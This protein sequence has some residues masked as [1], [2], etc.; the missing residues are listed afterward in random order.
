MLDPTVITV[1]EG[2]DE[3]PRNS[4]ASVVELNDG[5]LLLAWQQYLPSDM[6]CGDEAPNRI[7]A[8]TSRD[9]GLTWGEPGVLIEPDAG[10]TNVYSPSFVRLPDGELL[11]GYFHY[12]LLAGGEAPITSGFLRRSRDDGATW[13]D[14]QP[15]W[16]RQPL[17]CASHV[18]KRLPGGRLIWPIGK[19]IGKVWTPTDHEVHG[20]QYS[21]D[22]GRTWKLCDTWI[23]LPMRGAMEG[24]VEPLGDGRVM[25]VMR[26]QLGSVFQSFSEDG[27]ATWS[28]AQTTGLKSPESCP[29]LM[30]IPKTGDLLIV[31]NNSM[32]DPTWDGRNIASHFGK[33]SPLTVAVS[34]DDGQTWSH[35]RN[36]EDDPGWGYTNPAV[37]F[38]S[39][40]KGIL[41][42]FCIPYTDQWSMDVRYMHLRAAVFDVD[43][44]Y[45]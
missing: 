7:A 36:I 11:L 14:R 33:R 40:G 32:Y 12:N 28:K 20:A 1:A 21:D 35:V 16:T 45:H 2:T 30:R 6:R 41:T 8:V 13:S 43:W 42:Y 10:D 27:G 15:A 24:H 3:Y 17:G 19:Q 31:W 34:K 23:D 37:T 4:E 22:D 38:T 25:M 44:L 26:T 9:G 18:I 39:G 5:S 29:E